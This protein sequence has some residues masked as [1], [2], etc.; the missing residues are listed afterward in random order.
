MRRSE[1]RARPDELIE[2]GRDDPGPLGIEAKTLL[3]S[4]GNLYPILVVEW[5]V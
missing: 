3:G 1:I 2:F 5:C 4:S